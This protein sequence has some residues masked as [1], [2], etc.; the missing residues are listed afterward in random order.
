MLRRL[1]GWLLV[2]ISLISMGWCAGLLLQSGRLPQQSEIT[3]PTQTQPQILQTEPPR[4]IEGPM[5]CVIPGTPLIAQMLTVYEGPH[6]ENGTDNEITG[7]G[8][9]VRNTSNVYIEF[10]RLLVRQGNEELLFEGTYLPPGEAVMIIDKNGS[11]GCLGAVEECLCTRILFGNFA[12]ED[13][14]VDVQSS[15]ICSMTVTNLTSQTL[16][17]VRVFYKQY[18]PERQMYIGGITYSA[19]LTELEPGESRRITPY[20]Y[21]SARGK[22]VA[23]VVET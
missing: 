12:A 11:A 3:E 20:H 8:L 1:K 19:V 7:Y 18:L 23:V 6:L 17:C 4:I 13:K 16:R 21:V 15:G 9:V 22:V 2:F 5:P 10:T 14:Q